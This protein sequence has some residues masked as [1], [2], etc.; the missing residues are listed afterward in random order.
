M[1]AVSGAAVSKTGIYR[2]VI[3]LAFAVFAVGLGLMSMLDSRSSSVV[4]VIY[5]LITALGLGALFQTPLIAIQA[6]MPIKDMATSTGTFGFIRTLGG[7]V[8]ISI[9][10]TIFSSFLRKKIAR[11]P[12]LN[13]DTSA[14][15]LAESVRNL[16][17]IPDPTTRAA[18]IQVYSQSISKI[19]L[20]MAPIIAASFIMSLAIRNY[21]LQR[22][23]IDGNEKAPATTGDVE[24]GTVGNATLNSQEDGDNAEKHVSQTPSA[25]DIKDPS[26]IK[27]QV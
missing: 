27:E 24:K 2:P 20:V 4:K 18:V 15:G 6:A 7:T 21:T 13:F 10:Q 16:K 17:N 23:V 3:W 8:G 19:W 5:P 22:K 9:G 14:A 1:S 25:E 12:N 11:I 26:T